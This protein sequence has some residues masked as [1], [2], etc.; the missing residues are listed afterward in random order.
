MSSSN[1]PAGRTRPASAFEMPERVRLADTD[2]MGII[3]FSA[4]ARYIEIVEIEF[5]RTLGFTLPGLAAEGLVMPRVHIAYDFF[6]PALLDDELRI[7]LSV[8]GVGVHSVRMTIDIVRV[9][10]DTTVAE[11]T[12]VSACM[13]RDTRRS[14]ALPERLAAALRA[15]A[16]A[17]PLN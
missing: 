10:D 12:V 2:A 1:K 5:F 8:A 7:R 13:D 17:L 3:H 15:F 11:A 4:Y 9:A 6:K 14:I 16:P